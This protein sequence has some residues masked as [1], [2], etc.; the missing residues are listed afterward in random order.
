MAPSPSGTTAAPR[1]AIVS[2]TSATTIRL[3]MGSLVGGHGGAVGEPEA[4]AVH[5]LDKRR[6][7]DLAAQRREVHVEHLGR[8]VPVLVPG[9]L[10]DL[11]PADEPAGVGGQALEYRELL[12]SEG[13]LGAGHGHLPGA[14]VDGERA[15]PQHL[16][17]PRRSTARI[18]ASSSARPNGLTR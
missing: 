8:P 13:D 4:V 15:V 1:I 18:L 7:A 16:R 5:G 6:V 2:R 3:V 17:W 11:L 14:Q 9:P 12:G 10:D